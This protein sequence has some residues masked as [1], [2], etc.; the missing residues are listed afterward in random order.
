MRVNRLTDPRI[1]LFTLVD[2]R[3]DGVA[4]PLKNNIV[5]ASD[6]RAVLAFAKR[7]RSRQ[8]VRK[9][10]PALGQRLDDLPTRPDGNIKDPNRGVSEVLDAIDAMGLAGDDLDMDSAVV[11]VDAGDLGG[12]EVAIARLAL[13]Q[14]LR[15]VDPQLHALVGAAVGVLPRHLG[16]HDAL[17][18]RHEL[19]VARLDGAFVPRKVFVVDGPVQNV[20]DRLLPPVRVV[21]EAGAGGDGE[22]VE[23]QEGG[24]VAQ[25]GGADGPA[26]ARADAF[27]LLDG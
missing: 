12:A 22:V 27:G 19:Q 9:R 24:E 4:L 5:K 13:F 11:D 26:H 3:H 23:H 18:R 1:F 6:G 21:G 16:V 2:L 14:L 17:A 10:I 15:Q 8:G 20:R 7:R 25:L